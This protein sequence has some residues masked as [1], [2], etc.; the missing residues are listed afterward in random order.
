MQEQL[1]AVGVAVP[2]GRNLHREVVEVA[3]GRVR[4]SVDPATPQDFDLLV[5]SLDD[6]LCGI[7]IGAA[8]MDAAFFRHSPDSEGEPV[9]ER[10][11]SG[12]RFI[13]MAIPGVPKVHTVGMLKIQV[14]KAHVVGYE[15]GRKPTI[16][17]SPE[18][19]FVEVV[20][21]AGQHEELQ[22]PEAASLT[23][24]VVKEPWVVSLPTPTVTY[25]HF[26]SRLRSVQGPVT[27]PQKQGTDHY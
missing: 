3:T 16:M 12:R 15:A 21:D 25:F 10:E 18:G 17:S 27:L 20:G 24:I 8:A 11:I 23:T 2:C 7:G 4:M 22:L 6:S 5:D 19:D 13:K 14:N 26:G 9:R 1:P